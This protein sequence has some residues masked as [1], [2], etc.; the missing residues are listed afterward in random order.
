[1]DNTH[2]T[3][4][5]TL[6]EEPEQRPLPA[7]TTPATPADRRLLDAL[8][9]AICAI[10]ASGH[11]RYANRPFLQLFDDADGGP[12][13]WELE[14][15]LEGRSPHPLARAF[16]EE[17]PIHAAL[18]GGYREG[19]CD[20][21]LD[22][23]GRRLTLHYT[24][25]HLDGGGAVATFHDLSQ[26]EEE[27]RQRRERQQQLFRIARLDTLNEVATGIAHQM[28]QP[29]WAV[30]NFTHGCIN[31]LRRGEAV[32]EELIDA[33]DQISTQAKRA[34]G[35]I[36]ELREL[37]RRPAGPSQVT[38]LNQALRA[39]RPLLEVESTP[40]D[41][42][43]EYRLTDQPLPI[44]GDILK[45]QQVVLNLVKNSAE[46]AEG[47]TGHEIRIESR[48][49]ND[50]ARISVID[51]GPGIDDKLLP[52]IFDAFITTKP[53]GTGM[54]LSIARSAIETHHGRLWAEPEEGS[55]IAFHFT[56]PLKRVTGDR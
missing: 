39:L 32:T 3:T 36:E 33:L 22:A 24:L 51:N 31:R 35:H 6:K 14:S 53:L 48:L 10:D 1:M 50:A 28:H 47:G 25:T 7:P 44:Y 52:T 38:E 19:R 40:H 23:D 13:G 8:P 34:S 30:V 17:N 5:H 45:I 12:I 54:G 2:D 49:T 37:S 55:G 43:L 21:L 20:S 27:R 9:Q 42:T 11:I 15:L 18:A 16:G 56:L 26:G 46:A 4:A 41:C 29:L